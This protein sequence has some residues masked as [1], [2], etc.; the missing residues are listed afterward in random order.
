MTNLQQYRVVVRIN[1]RRP[2]KRNRVIDVTPAVAKRL[3]FKHDGLTKV[4][5]DV[6]KHPKREPRLADD[7]SRGKTKRAVAR[8][9][10]RRA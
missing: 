7:E 4:R 5:I 2:Y 1:D 6:L 9:G 3:G 8:K 10:P